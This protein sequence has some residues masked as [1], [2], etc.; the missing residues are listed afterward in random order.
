[1]YTFNFS[2]EDVLRLVA[3]T[4]KA[5]KHI[6][7]FSERYDEATDPY[8]KTVAGKPA[9]Q[10]VKDSGVYLMSN[11]QRRPNSVRPKKDIVYADGYPEGTHLRGDDF[12]EHFP[13]EDIEGLNLKPTDT[14][15]IEMDMYGD[16]M[17][18]GVLR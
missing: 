12:V 2:G 6:P 9:I 3:K 8:D 7:S 13:L 16:T 15:F 14:L 18:L 5:K 1:M 11:A 4:R 17:N 10:F